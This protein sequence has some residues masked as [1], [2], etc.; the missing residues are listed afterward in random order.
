MNARF[1]I[2]STCFL[3]LFIHLRITVFSASKAKIRHFP[4]NVPYGVHCGHDSHAEP[5][6]ERK[7]PTGPAGF[8]P[9]MCCK[10]RS[11]EIVPAPMS[12]SDHRRAHISPRR[13]P[14]SRASCVITL[15]CVGASY[16]ASSRRTTSFSSSART[17]TSCAFGA[18][19]RLHGFSVTSPHCTALVNTLDSIR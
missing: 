9:G 1:Y 6:T 7:Q 11:I 2:E 19:A 16:K 5:Q 18:S 15:Y 14:V 10:V 17:S 4:G 8:L 12:I 13:A 3:C